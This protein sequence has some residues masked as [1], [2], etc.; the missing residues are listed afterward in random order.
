[1]TAE[2][3]WQAASQAVLNASV[4]SDMPSPIAPNFCTSKTILELL[5]LPSSDGIA[6]SGAG[7]GG[8]EIVDIL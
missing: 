6:G 4:S 5:A 1:M 7:V 2:S 8:S 3:T